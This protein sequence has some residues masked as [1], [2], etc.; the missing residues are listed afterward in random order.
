[1]MQDD[2]AAVGTNRVP[3]DPPF[4]RRRV[5]AAL[6]VLL[7]FLSSSF[8]RPTQ[9]DR[10]VPG[11]EGERAVKMDLPVKVPALPVVERF[12]R[13]RITWE[14]LHV[15]SASSGPGEGLIL[16]LGDP[17]LEGRIYSGPYPFEA[18]RTES[19]YAR[20]RTVRPLS[21]GRGCIALASF[22]LTPFN[23]N[24]WPEGP[25]GLSSPSMTAA[26]R[27]ELHLRPHDGGC[28]ALGFYEG[29]AGFRRTGKGGFEKTLTLTEGPY[30]TRLSSDD[31]TS[32]VVVFRTDRTARG[33]VRVRPAG[34]AG[35]GAL[36]AEDRSSTLHEVRISGL[37]PGVE[38]G[39]EVR[40]EDGSGDEY[41]TGR[42]RF[43][44]APSPGAD[45]VRF[46]FVSDTREGV[47]GGERAFAGHN[48]YCLRRILSH[49]MRQGAELFLFG[50]DLVNGYTSSKADFR[51]QFRAWKGSVSGFW[52]TRPV[53]TAMGNHETL[54]QWHYLVP[55]IF[56]AVD[57]WYLRGPPFYVAL[58]RFPYATESAEAVF[59]EEFYNFANGPEPSDSRRPPYR[60]NVYTFQWGP[61]RFVAFNNNYWWTTN[62]AVPACGGAPEGYM[63]EDQ[64][65]WIEG[66]LARAEADPTVKFVILFA[67]E[68]VF[69]CGGHVG[70]A[71]W[72]NG[73]N[74]VRAYT[75]REGHMVPERAGILEV[76]NRFWRAV[77]ACSK[78]AAVLAGDEHAYHRLLVDGS[79]PVGVYPEDDL[80]GDGKVDRFSPDPAFVRPVWHLTAGTGG[81]PYY[82]ETPTPWTPVCYSSEEGYLLFETEGG[83]ISATFYTVSGRILD[84][85]DDLMAVKR[86]GKSGN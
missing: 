15:V 7:L 59:A 75:F 47:G 71:M 27:V 21:K 36:F 49:A 77:A 78:S 61:V 8:G 19:D 50:G 53:Y 69:P 54:L 82:C 45:R 38:Y 79:T 70:D 72:W 58:D 84:R 31:P 74:G 57:R 56:A 2:S 17:D 52:R 22:F 48:A 13:N 4:P 85:V 68:P 34:G 24:Q 44:A 32:A 23:V 40:V 28:R 3:A 16:D 46:A 30:L 63:L 10:T 26:Y 11:K 83:R 80:D 37:D 20:Y 43:H 66:V 76:R 62:A 60:E 64:L 25:P 6:A 67:Q 42:Y 14:A 86:K 5:F 81:A 12:V 35:E 33:R 55:F 9:G 65:S 18:G 51:L 39:Y 29:V 41:H 73:N 1:M